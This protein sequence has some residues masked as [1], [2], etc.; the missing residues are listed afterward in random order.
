MEKNKPFLLSAQCAMFFRPN[1]SIDKNE[2]I[3][4]LTKIISKCGDLLD[5]E[6]T[7][8]PIPLDAPPDIPRLQI[9]SKDNSYAYGI[10]LKRSDFGF[11]EIGEPSKKIEDIRINLFKYEGELLDIYKD[12]KAWSISRL[13]LV[14]NY[15]VELDDFAAK[16]IAQ[17]FITEAP[18]YNSIELSL[19]KKCKMQTFD[20]NRWIRIKPLEKKENTLHILV[21][22]NTFAEEKL[23]LPSAEMKKFYEYAVLYIEN[24]LKET[25]GDI[26]NE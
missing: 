3:E 25:L 21:D 11:N 24:E 23:S 6:P 22:V 26:F 2:K 15:V 16:F 12:E 13:A 8:L 4:L 20:I 10:S 1:I 17:K 18:A 19:L 14:V 7:I 5:G 9:S